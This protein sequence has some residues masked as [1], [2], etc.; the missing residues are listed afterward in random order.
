MPGILRQNGRSFSKSLGWASAQAGAPR[1]F[2]APAESAMNQERETIFCAY[3][4]ELEAGQALLAELHCRLELPWKLEKPWPPLDLLP[5]IRKN[6]A[7]VHN[8]RVTCAKVVDKMEQE[9]T[10]QAN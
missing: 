4:A 10:T 6:M 5:A 1:G 3:L 9:R 8:L 7:S 2:G